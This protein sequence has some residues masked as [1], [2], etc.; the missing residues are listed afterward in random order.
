MIRKLLLITTFLSSLAA[1]SVMAADQ[2]AESPADAA[3]ADA[4]ELFSDADSSDSDSKADMGDEAPPSYDRML[5][6]VYDES[7]IYSIPTKCGYQTSIVFDSEEE[8]QTISVGDRSTWQI[9]P[10]GSR[11]FIRP[12]VE[13]VATNMTV[14]TNKRSYQFDIKST[15]VKGGRVIYVAK[16]TYKPETPPAPPSLPAVSVPPASPVVAGSAPAETPAGFVPPPAQPRSERPEAPRPPVHTGETSPQNPNYSYT[17]SGPDD[18]APLQVYDD[19]TNTYIKYRNS[20]Q[21]TPNAFL[22]SD[23]NETLVPSTVRDGYLVLTNTVAGEFTLKNSN[24]TVHIYN[25]TINPR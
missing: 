2:A 15:R 11:L 5:N 19:G 20:D 21:P 1:T 24:G 7:D 14:I 3:A 23:G 12:L 13:G 9:I 17:Y 6:L 10:A 25:E 18:L 4:K 16:F 8:I 22:V